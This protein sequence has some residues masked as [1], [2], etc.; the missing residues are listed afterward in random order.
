MG[1]LSAL[2]RDCRVAQAALLGPTGVGI[3]AMCAAAAEWPQFCARGEGGAPLSTAARAA[4]RKL[5]RRALW[6]LRHLTS[7]TAP[8]AALAALMCSPTAPGALPSLLAVVR[9]EGGGEG[10][11]GG[12]LSD[13]LDAREAA[14]GCLL[15]LALPAE[16]I[17]AGVDDL[18]DSRAPRGLFEGGGKGGKG[19]EG[20]EVLLLGGPAGEEAGGSG[21]GGSSGAVPPSPLSAVPSSMPLA[22]RRA[23][24][25][26]AGAPALLSRHADWCR[27]REAACKKGGDE[28]GAE[29][30]AAEGE[31]SAR[32]AAAAATRE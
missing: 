26:A 29:A 17:S 25:Q 15:A 24:L 32:A 13:C 5:A 8:E 16:S 2:V 30:Y 4:G 11:V 19:G 21:S 9:E 7:G 28:A 20:G 10:G 14:V 31:A 3:G 6:L 22:A 12:E 18:Q 23:A 1:A 27:E